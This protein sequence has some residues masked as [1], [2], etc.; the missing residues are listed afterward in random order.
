MGAVR[1]VNWVSQSLGVAITTLRI[2]GLRRSST[3]EAENVLVIERA[4]LQGTC[5]KERPY[6]QIG[7]KGL[8]LHRRIL[9]VSVKLF[10][11]E[12]ATS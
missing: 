11:V 9:T 6:S 10:W 3:P 2:A 5:L 7:S 4:G 12:V 1:L 8:E